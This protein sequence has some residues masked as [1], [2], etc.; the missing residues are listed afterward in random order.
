MGANDIQAGGVFV[1]RGI[2]FEKREKPGLSD[3][4]EAIVFLQAENAGAHRAR[5]ANRRVQNASEKYVFGN[6]ADL[7]V[8]IVGFFERVH[9]VHDKSAVIAFVLQARIETKIFTLGMPQGKVS[10]EGENT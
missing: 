9:E 7:A 4:D 2:A 1:L 8:L 10:P 5:A 3:R 6:F